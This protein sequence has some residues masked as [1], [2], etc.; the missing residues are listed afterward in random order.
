MSD[1]K[2]LWMNTSK[3]DRQTIYIYLNELG[4]KIYGNIVT[5]CGYYNPYPEDSVHKNAYCR[6]L[7][8]KYVGSYNNDK[9]E[10]PSV[11]D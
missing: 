10:Y 2:Y 11:Y 6:G 3:Q 5:G 9:Y 8:V 1:T 4:K 7:A